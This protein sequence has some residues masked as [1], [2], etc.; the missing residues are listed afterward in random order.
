MS[1]PPPHN[2]RMNTE[3]CGRKTKNVIPP[4]GPGLRALCAAF[5]IAPVLLGSVFSLKPRLDPDSIHVVPRYSTL[6]HDKKFFLECAETHS[7]PRSRKEPSSNLKPS[8]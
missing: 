7:I 2:A 6:L 3:L 4:P 8:N 1:D 5:L